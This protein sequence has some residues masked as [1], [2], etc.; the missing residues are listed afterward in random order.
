[1]TEQE[2]DKWVFRIKHFLI[3]FFIL[4]FALGAHFYIKYS[5][6]LERSMIDFYNWLCDLTTAQQLGL[7]FMQFVCTISGYALTRNLAQTDFV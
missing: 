4:F 3:M 1:M 2:F 7:C 5:Q 6:L